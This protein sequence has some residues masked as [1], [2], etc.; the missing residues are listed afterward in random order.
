MGAQ[1]GYWPRV[2]FESPQ[3]LPRVRFTL[4]LTTACNMR[5]DYCYAPPQAG[6]VMSFETACQALDLAARLNPD[7]VAGIALF[8][9]E[10][11]LCQDLIRAL[12]AEAQQR[13]REGRGRFHFKL[14]TN[15]L[16]LTP[17]FL[18]YSVE[19]R[20]Q[21]AMS[22]D[23]VRA[24]HDRHR[25][26]PGGGP[27]F[28]LLLPKLELLLARRPYATVFMTV[29]ADTVQHYAESVAFLLDQGVRYVVSSMN[30][31][32]PWTEA[33]LDELER[34]YER[35]AQLYLQWSRAGRKFYFSPFEQKLASHVQGED[36]KRC[37]CALT[38]RQVSADPEGW[39]Y[40]C[41]QFARGG[42][43]WRI[44]HVATGFDQVAR[45]R[46]ASL[47][48]AQKRPCAD[49]ALEHRCFHTCACLNW[50][51]T[52]ALDQVS[53]VLCRHERILVPLADGVGE[54]L[55]REGN[56]GFFMKHYDPAGPLRS[57]MEDLA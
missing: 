8:G 11:L 40:P 45:Q 35:L 22:L 21:I 20:I 14:T 6:R 4:H 15:G 31:A 38:E 43:A 23:G 34:Q 10:P 54:A 17:E 24:C 57:L 52:G 25:R 3:V 50:Q 48:R 30:Y 18:D 27:S 12:V 2:Q 36:W 56:Q 42:E 44:G 5:C 32:G 39:L 33:S 55:Y 46:L 7:D 47:A 26:L 28:D 53:P 41:V 19:N 16:A 51:A 1:S 13:R 29:E 37:R 49:C 9:G